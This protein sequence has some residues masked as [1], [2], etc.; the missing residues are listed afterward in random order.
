M[1]GKMKVSKARKMRWGRESI[2]DVPPENLNDSDTEYLDR[3][4]PLRVIRSLFPLPTVSSGEVVSKK[5][6]K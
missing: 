2:E 5:E 3:A 6:T 1:P 4:A